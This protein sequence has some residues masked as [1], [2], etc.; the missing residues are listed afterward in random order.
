MCISDLQYDEGQFWLVLE[1]Q[2]THDGEIPSVRLPLNPE[3]LMPP[4]SP[5]LLW[6][7]QTP[8]EYPR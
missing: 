7:Y 6:V 4:S 8:V 3:L 5:A 1:W 2:E